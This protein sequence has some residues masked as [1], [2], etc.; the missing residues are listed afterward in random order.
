MKQPWKTTLTAVALSCTLLTGAYPA[1][2]DSGAAT[3]APL[4]YALTGSLQVAV[5]S[6][7]NEY[8]SSGTGLGVVVRVTNTSTRVTRVPDYE[9]RLRT[10]EGVEY[11]LAPSSSNVRSVQPKGSVELNYIAS[12]DSDG[13]F[14]VTDLVWT[15]VNLDVYPKTETVKLDVP[16]DGSVWQGDLTMLSD[17]SA[18]KSW[19][20]SFTLP[21]LNSP[22]RY[23][24]A[25]FT[26]DTASGKPVYVVQLLVTNPSAW[27]QTLPEFSLSGV[28]GSKA[29]AGSRVEQGPIKLE[30]GESS[31]VHVA[32]PVD[33]DV[34]LSRLNVLSPETFRV[35]GSAVTYNV[36]RLQIGLPQGD[37]QQ[38][39]AAASDKAF[40]QPIAFDP[41][42]QLLPSG[43]SVSLMSLQRFENDGESFGTAVAKLKIVNQGDTA[44]GVPVMG[45][46]LVSE[47]GYTYPGAKS[48]AAA[49]GAGASAAGAAAA[50]TT[51]Q[52]VLPGTG[53]VVSYTFTLPKSD[54][55]QRF[56]LKLSD[57]KAAAPYKSEIA[58]LYVPL[59]QDDTSDTKLTMYPYE[60]TL[61]D[62]N[63]SA[64]ASQGLAGIS[65]S[66]QLKTN[67]AVKQVE[68]LIVDPSLT[69][70]TVEVEDGTGNVAGS[71]TVALTGAE[72]L[73]S[74]DQKLVLSSGTGQLDYPLTLKFYE[75]VSTPNGDVKRL[76]YSY[77]Y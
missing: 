12:V 19:G 48:G 69:R 17:P 8:D 26:K 53:T 3:P 56:A 54:E 34:T 38:A 45:A 44:I 36:G 77:K 16:L 18:I 71:K 33:E 43:V 47:N 13:A 57:I 30:P 9:V 15:D 42:S 24:T 21:A 41:H 50:G 61:R 72:R 11:T 70:L 75:T 2:A 1:L 59:Q 58:K 28:S 52:Q 73:I 68:P 74:G 49:A 4:S 55:S 67:L 20:D 40:G 37:D 6:V 63:L 46:D 76:L 65:Y 51:A 31:Y 60:V 27:T 10:A 35:A 5:K 14:S 23:A 62:W 7:L 25:G 29:F 32:I 22:L 39:I 66:Y 64:V